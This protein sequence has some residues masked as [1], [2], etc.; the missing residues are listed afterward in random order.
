M[1]NKLINQYED[2]SQKFKQLEHASQKKL[3]KLA[4]TRLLSF[5]LAIL[6]FSL[7]L[8]HNLVI[9]LTSSI[10]FLIIFVFSIIKYNK[11]KILKNHYQKL[12]EINYLE[13]TALKGDFS[14]FANGKEFINRSGLFYLRL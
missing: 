5:V 2:N 10:C 8:K 3:N 9:A 4:F 1:I 12:K 11:L 13:I 14:G 7:I 6:F